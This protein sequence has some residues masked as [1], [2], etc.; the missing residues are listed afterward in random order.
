MPK[1][2]VIIPCFN[3]GQFL[4][5][6]VDSVVAQTYEDLE[7]IIVNDGSDDKQTREVLDNLN[8]DRARIIHTENQGL[9]C[10]LNRGVTESDGAYILPLDADDKIA[11]TYVEKAVEVLDSDEDAGI[12]YCQAELFGE[13]T[14]RWELPEYRFPDILLGNVI[15][16]AALFRKSDWQKVNGYNPNMRL[17]LQDFDLWLSLIELGRRVVCIPEVLFFYRKHAGSKSGKIGHRELVG[18]YTQ[19]FRNHPKL[20]SDNISS[21]FENIVA[22]REQSQLK[23]ERIESLAEGL[24][25]NEAAIDWLSAQVNAK[26][27]IIR[28]RDEAVSYLSENKKNEEQALRDRMA[29]L[30]DREKAIRAQEELVET[31]KENLGS[32]QEKSRRLAALNELLQ[33]QLETAQQAELVLSSQLGAK[34]A[35]L[36]RIMRSVGWRLLSRFGSIKYRY[37]LPVYR[38]LGLMPFDRK[39]VAQQ[40]AIAAD[41]RPSAEQEQTARSIAA[42][43]SELRQAIDAISIEESGRRPSSGQNEKKR[44]DPYRP[45]TLLPHL[46]EEQLP[47][48][49]EMPA[50]DRPSHRADVIC[51]SIIDWEFRYQRPQQIMS[52][53]AA[54]GHRVFY[55]S[56]SRF[57]HSTESSRLVVS[58]IKNNLYEV[59]LSAERP[60]DVYS[61]VI[62]AGTV[63]ESLAELRR[64]FHI[65]EAVAYVMIA[66]WG[67]A[68]LETS[69][70][71]NWRVVYD[72]MDEWENFPGINRQLLDMEVNLVERCD[73]LV[74]TAQRLY[75]KW[76]PYHRPAVLA[77]N[78]VDYEFYA[79]LCRPNTKLSEIKH[80]VVGYYGAIAD[81]FDVELVAFAAK[82]RPQ[83][84][85]VLLGGVFD[86]DVTSLQK[87]PNVSLLG[88][89]PYETMPQYLYHFDACII[90]FKLN[91]ITEATDPVKLYEYLSAGKPVVSV[92]LPEL[93]PFSNYLYIA[94]DK[95]DFI[96]QLDKAVGEDDCALADL[97][98]EFAKENTWRERYELI[99]DGLRESTP[100]ASIIVVTYNNLALTKLCLESVIRNT[101]YPNYE[102]VV[103]D[104]SSSDGTPG[105]LRYLAAHDSK[106]H[107]ILNSENAGFARA[108]NQGIAGSAGDYVVLLNNDT[109]VPP[110]WLSR[111]LRHL[112][113]P[114]VGIVG[115]MSNFVG[116]EARIPVTYETWG[117]M[118]R[119]AR[120]YVDAH[121][122]QVADINMLAMF[123]VAL[124]RGAYDEVGPLDE[125][126]GLG[127]FEDDDYAQR[128][129]A[130]GYRVICAADVFVH[131][132]GQASFKKLIENGEYDELFEENRRR[133][134][135]KWDIQWTAH[136]SEGLDF[137]S[138][139]TPLAQE[140]PKEKAGYGS[141]RIKDTD[142]RRSST[143]VTAQGKKVSD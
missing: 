58:K 61:E 56:T 54:N 27:Q 63:L 42:Q 93:E 124:R 70:L 74:V 8:V 72:C 86:V 39:T 126:F 52:Q 38:L 80:P 66:S 97:R 73:L 65:D 59:Q 130:A 5:E 89:Q 55:I 46:S 69:R 22:L 29:Q 32:S 79:G 133:Y 48:I 1:V 135:A 3:Q 16:D 50:P 120:D 118:E 12:V 25:R 85:F 51:F 36:S 44:F 82:Q 108:N 123:C 23:A 107:I 116:N 71:W 132:F 142:F 75:D 111:L 37:L 60:P 35:E 6:A 119:F 127:M 7:M 88:Q 101:E 49:L 17:G 14:G 134:E 138:A 140:D 47:G 114:A 57:R 115:P 91:A 112:R 103:V 95:H 21:I 94:S 31:L 18:L 77:R 64:T 33:A 92:A 109:I 96:S 121:D 53:F 13:R 98:R 24:A 117:E 136:K 76:Q 87:L 2:S 30:A 11:S 15:F 125:Q 110:G 81:W 68:A 84:S 128:M 113:N 143:S 131:H 19:L 104:N 129:R 122:G 43:L 90:P 10:A 100:R 105:Y 20:Y 26:D 102:V 62:D 141:E 34:D 137:R 83:Y 106:F 40:Q 9:P 41:S 4:R 78:A 67:Q 139:W 45:L 99:A 28:A